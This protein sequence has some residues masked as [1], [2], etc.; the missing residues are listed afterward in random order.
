MSDLLHKAHMMDCKVISMPS[1]PNIKLT[2]HG[3]ESTKDVTLYRSI[4]G[5]LQYLSFTR[6][7]V[8]FSVHKVPK[9]MHNPTEDHW[10]VI[11]WI[12]RHL[13]QTKNHGLFLTKSTDN[14]TNIY[15]DAE[16]ASNPN[17]RKSTSDYTIFLG[18]GKMVTVQFLLPAKHKEEAPKPTDERVI[19]EEG[20]GYGVV[21]F[22]DVAADQVMKEKVEKLK[23]SLERDGYKRLESSCWQGI[24]HP[25]LC[26]LSELMK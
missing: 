13:Q 5:G 7:D 14:N 4:V 25:G 3:G 1:T 10:F 24:N 8:S 11:K 23:K 18:R 12:L 22:A 26:L 19:R 17:D 6:L 16:W 21:N 2:E 20:R 15:T 9:Y